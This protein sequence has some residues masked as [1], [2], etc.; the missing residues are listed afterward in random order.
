VV[1]ATWNCVLCSVDI[2]SADTEHSEII[3]SQEEREI[4]GSTGDQGMQ[5]SEAT[6][7]RPTQA[8][9]SCTTKPKKHKVCAEK[10]L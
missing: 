9:L 10:S 5:P 7:S 2:D 8:Q 1:T 6:L 3:E 4:I